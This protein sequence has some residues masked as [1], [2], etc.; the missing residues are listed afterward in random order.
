MC[1]LISS[2]S[3]TLNGSLLSPMSDTIPSKPAAALGVDHT[4]ECHDPFREPTG[5]G[6]YPEQYQACDKQ[7]E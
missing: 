3:M 5:L 4:P 7:P 1:L 2:T 6:V